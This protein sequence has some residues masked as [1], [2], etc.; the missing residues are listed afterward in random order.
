MYKGKF[1]H[2]AKNEWR[3]TKECRIQ[4]IIYSLSNID[5]FE[6]AHHDFNRKGERKKKIES[7]KNW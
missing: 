7:L 6:S 1:D 2:K 4:S 3:P 5:L